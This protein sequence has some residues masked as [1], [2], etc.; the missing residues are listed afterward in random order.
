MRLARRT[1]PSEVEENIALLP[2]DPGVYL[3]HD[4]EDTVI[5]VGKASCLK[6]RVRQYFH[7]GAKHAPKVRAMVEKVHRVEWIV[8]KTELEAFVL[9]SN[10]IKRYRPHYNILLKDD[11]HYPYVRIDLHEDFPR[12]EITRRIHRDGAR[13]FGPYLA[14][15]TIREIMD[16]LRD[17]FPLRTCRQ[18][19]P[20]ETAVRPCLHYHLGRCLAPCAGKVSREEYHAIIRQV[21]AFLSGKHAEIIAQLTE[22]M[23]EASAALRFEQAAMLRD[24]IESI[25]EIMQ[26]QQAISTRG[27]NQDAIGIASSGGRTIVQ[28]LYI[29]NG[30]LLGSES[31]EMMQTEGETEETLLE[32][33]LTQHYADAPFLPDRILLPR[34]PENASELEDWLSQRRGAHVTLLVPQRGDPMRMLTMAQK[35]AQEALLRAAAQ[36]SREYART[37]GALEDLARHLSLP[38][39]PHRIEAY[40]ISHTSGVDTVASMVVMTDGVPDKSQYRKFKIRSVQG[41]DDFASMH[42]VILRRFT[43]GETEQ[44]ARRFGP[45][46][47]LVLI[48]GGLGQLHAARD[49]MR[50]ACCDSI[51]TAALAKQFEWLYTEERGNDPIVLPH[52][53][54]ALQLLQRLRDEAHRFAITFQRALRGKRQTH[55]VLEDIPGIGKTR[56]AALL[57]TF[58]SLKAIREASLEELLA[59]DGMSRPAAEAVQAFFREKG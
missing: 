18:K 8:T 47:D 38:A 2:D 53:A 4:A 27:E 40:D 28:L 22:Q 55:S 45:R 51:P 44:E 32:S 11:K 10:L 36:K 35:N 14:A 23:Q 20:R 37:L 52:D 48:D 19:L 5:Y 17:I 9:E 41:I 16:V 29:R 15:H 59:V 30:K 34:L 33:F 21:C 25:R 6:N 13:Y 7:A 50:E 42:E 57:R 58:R 3:M 24:R 39:P 43:H 31:L 1:W 56:R 26:K 46:P 12:V 49:A 54:F